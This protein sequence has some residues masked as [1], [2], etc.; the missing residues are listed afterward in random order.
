MTR[1]IKSVD[2]LLGQCRSVQ[3]TWDTLPE[4]LFRIISRNMVVSLDKFK[5]GQSIVYGGFTLQASVDSQTKQG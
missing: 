5:L 1:V 3:E 2:D 4:V